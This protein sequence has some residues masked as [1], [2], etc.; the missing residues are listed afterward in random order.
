MNDA[1]QRSSSHLNPCPRS[2]MTMRCM[3]PFLLQL[4]SWAFSFLAPELQRA[5]AAAGAKDRATE[6]TLCTCSVDFWVETSHHQVSR[7][8]WAHA[9]ISTPL[10]FCTFSHRS[11][12]MPGSCTHQVWRVSEDSDAVSSHLET[13]KVRGWP[14]GQSDC[15]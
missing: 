7:A 8:H 10:R 3:C 6:H 12:S 11:N 15:R 9:R 1:C 5:R 13:A 2:H 4:I 14:R